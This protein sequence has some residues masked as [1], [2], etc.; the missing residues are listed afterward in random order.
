[1]RFK[2]FYFGERVSFVNLSS[3]KSGENLG[4]IDTEKDK[5]IVPQLKNVLNQTAITTLVKDM[6][7]QHQFPT[8]GD[9]PAKFTDLMLRHFQGDISTF[10]K[11]WK[12]PPSVATVDGQQDLSTV[13]SAYSEWL[14]QEFFDTLVAWTPPIGGVALGKVE[15]MLGLMSNLKHAIRGGDLTDGKLKIEVKGPRAR[16]AGQS[17]AGQKRIG[18]VVAKDM[19]DFLTKLYGGAANLDK[20]TS[21]LAKTLTSAKA[22]SKGLLTAFFQAVVTQ[23]AKITP[24]HL[25]EI[26][27]IFTNYNDTPI[28][29]E[30]VAML[31]QAINSNN[32]SDFLMK[33]V[34]P[35]SL[36][37][38]ASKE[39]LNYL[40]VVDAGYTKFYM[41]NMDSKS[42]QKMS[43]FISEHMTVEWAWDQTRA[44]P[45]Y[46]YKG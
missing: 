1:M 34:A 12:N 15:M 36:W 14:P 9:L 8:N 20:S 2:Q 31:K 24:V 10:E 27:R 33:V 45:A 35:L 38:Y 26:V 21:G 16:F 39:D 4:Q 11:R 46:T 6:F 7:K 37:G 43:D 28:P 40:M 29:P 22:L 44:S 3:T 5:H 23:K 18:P 32:P 25:K 19:L 30:A 13:A 42:F 17:S 41:F